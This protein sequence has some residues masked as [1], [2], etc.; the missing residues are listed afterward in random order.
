MF[1]YGKLPAVIAVDFQKG[2]TSP[3]NP[4]GSCLDEMIEQNEQLVETAHKNDVPVIW[5][6]VIYTH[7]TAVVAGVPHPRLDGF[8]AIVGAAKTSHAASAWQPLREAT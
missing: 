7:P 6:R 8:V 1:G 4:L 2:M 3:E 5:T